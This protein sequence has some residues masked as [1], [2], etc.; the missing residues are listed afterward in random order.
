MPGTPI[1]AAGFAAQLMRRRDQP[2][3]PPLVL[4]LH[5]G[6]FVTRPAAPAPLVAQ[7]LAAAGASVVSL[8]YPLAP[9]HPFPQALEAA[10]EALVW[11]HEQRRVLAELNSPLIVAGEEAG[12]NLAAAL[13]LM[14]RDRGAPRLA[15]QIL[16]S[17]MLDPFMTTASARAAGAGHAHCPVAE[18]WRQYLPRCADAMHPYAA[19][20]QSQRLGGLPPALIVTAQNDG[21]RDEAKTYAA[22]LRAAKVGV[23]ERVL[24]LGAAWPACLAGNDLDP[25][26]A[27]P[28]G[29]AFEQFFAGLQ[30]S[31]RRDAA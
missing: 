29:V 19:P 13:A 28:L 4:H 3:N 30:P 15:G 5:G 2:R 31:G 16:L 24:D 1:Q 27:A 20:L 9:Q 17:P 8:D 18:G 11:M 6:E 14:A 12:G 26:W 7:L 10:H 23:Q 25:L 22:K 21:L